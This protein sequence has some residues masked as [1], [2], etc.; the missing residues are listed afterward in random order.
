M[1]TDSSEE[2]I[3]PLF[4]LGRVVMA[5]SLQARLRDASPDRWEAEVVGLISRHMSGDWGDLDE[6][7]KRE[8][9]LALSRGLR[10]LSAY[11]TSSG[12]K[13]WIISEADRSVTTV[14]LPEDY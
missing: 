7:D 12:L 1:V 3:E 11:E 10:I 6:E 4:P 9:N 13:I 5:P 2:N 8:N 14:L